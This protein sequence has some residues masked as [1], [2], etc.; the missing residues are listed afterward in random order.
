MEDKVQGEQFSPHSLHLDVNH[1]KDLKKSGLSEETIQQAKIYSV[2]PCDI[3]K[4]LGANYSWMEGKSLM[5]FPYPECDGF[6]R[7]KVFP[8]TE[9]QPK[10]LQKKDTGNRIYILEKVRPLL[11]NP[12]I[13]LYITEGEKKTLKV[14]QEG[15]LCIGL[16][17]LWNWSDGSEDKNLIPDF[18]KIALQSREVFIVPDNDWLNPNRHGEPKNLR[19]AVNKLA[20]RL[21]DRGAKPFIIHLPEGSLKGIDDYLSKHSVEEFKKLAK[22][23]VKKQTL[24]EMI[25]TAFVD[26]LGDIKKRMVLLNESEKEVYVGKLAKKFGIPKPAIRV[27][28]EKMQG[29]GTG[30]DEKIEKLLNSESQKQTRFS[31]MEF[32]DDQLFY[33][34]IWDCEKILLKSDGNIILSNPIHSCKFTRSNLTQQ[35]AKRYKSGDLVGGIKLIHRLTHLFSSHIFFKD[36]RIP[37]LLAIWVMGTY[38]FKIFKFYGY[39]LLKSPE[40]RCGKSLLLDILSLVC[41]NA[42]PRSIIP[43]EASIYRE[44]DGNAATQIFDE[45]ESLGTQDKEKKADLMS[46][47]NAGFQKGSA[48][49]RMEKRGDEF[50]QVYYFVYSPKALAGIKKI[51][52]T[53]EDRSLRIMMERK[54]PTE[55]IK[56]FNLRKQEPEIEILKE[57]LFIW[58]LRNSGDIVEIYEEAEKF[59]GIEGIDDRQKDILEPLLS[60]AHIIDAEEG[61]ENLKTFN[62]LVDL[63]LDMSKGRLER[64]KTDSAIPALIEITKEFL[65]GQEEKLVSSNDFFI[66]VQEDESLKFISSKKGLSN[67]LSRFE[68]HP[69]LRKESG[70]TMRSYFITQK[71]IN[72]LGRYV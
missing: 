7:Y 66:R 24:D 47:L 62:K 12:S 42:T 59:Q 25:K 23:E 21:I 68:L 51:I 44:V 1:L 16:G 8:S 4:Q 64:E 56:R 52:D 55:K 10:Y 69:S 60:I 31:A 32:I 2:P 28:L 46:L 50:V 45:V 57:D 9:G 11:S 22:S 63:S 5:A 33:G 67:F 30:K 19:E 15:L 61:D 27:D 40:K 38:L 3:D 17:G 34:G 37:L 18:E 6:E 20:H 48:V 26:D 35:I 72:D 49:S 36:E 54:L 58:A 14:C 53:I 43:S 71:W 70:K 13:P 29:K 65:N 41:F 39:V